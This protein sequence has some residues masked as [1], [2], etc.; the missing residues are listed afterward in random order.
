MVLLSTG[1]FSHHHRNHLDGYLPSP[2]DEEATIAKTTNAE[3]C[4]PYQ[5]AARHLQTQ[6]TLLLD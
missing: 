1:Y 4:E 3:P 2:P 6:D 5:A